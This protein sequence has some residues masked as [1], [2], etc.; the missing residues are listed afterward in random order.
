MRDQ[1][2]SGPDD[3]E[4]RTIS[5]ELID[6]DDLHDAVRELVGHGKTTWGRGST[7]LSARLVT[8]WHGDAVLDIRVTSPS[9]GG[10]TLC[11][12]SRQRGT[13]DEQAL[14]SSLR[15]ALATA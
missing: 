14:T 5:S 13:Y 10:S 3:G 2:L 8:F 12:V 11:R 9:Q 7:L 6:P 15:D 1:A 4:Q